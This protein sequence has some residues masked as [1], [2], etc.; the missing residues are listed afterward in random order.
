MPFPNGLASASSVSDELSFCCPLP[1]QDELSFRDAPSDREGPRVIDR[2]G[3]ERIG[4][5]SSRSSVQRGWI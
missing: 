2:E 4:L 5:S 3:R 1:K